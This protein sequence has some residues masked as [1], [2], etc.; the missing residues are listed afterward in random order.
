MTFQIEP[1][2]SDFHMISPSAVSTNPTQ[3]ASTPGGP[4]SLLSPTDTALS[5]GG[6]GTVSLATSREEEE[7]SSNQDS[8]KSPGNR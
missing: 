3:V 6:T 1:P 4:M 5:P 7:D 2:N 8:N